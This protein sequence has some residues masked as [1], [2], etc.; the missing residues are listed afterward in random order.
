MGWVRKVCARLCVLVKLVSLAGVLIPC[1]LT[2]A[3]KSIGPMKRKTVLITGAT[4]GIGLETAKIF[5]T[6]GHSVLLHGRN[7]AKLEKVAQELSSFSLDAVIEQYVADFSQIEDVE[8]LAKAV[9]KKH[10]KLDILINNAGVLKSAKTVVK[11]GLDVRFMVNT[12]APYLLTKRLLPLFNESGR[13]INLSSAAQSPVNLKALSG[14]VKLRDMEA[15]AQSK[16]ALTMWS[17]QLAL[18]HPNGPVIV[19][20]NPGSLLASKMVKE[21]FGVSGNKLSIGADILV[22]ASLSDEFA[23]ASGQ[24]YDNDKR[25]FA[26]PHADALNDQKSQAVMAAINGILKESN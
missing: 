8:A 1:A 21:A 4:D 10:K 20:V 2:S 25:A 24:Y 26:R 19:A 7:P 17:R 9:S 12:V 14:G 23:G 11:S 22:R 13:I 16:L 6:Q 3:P 18:S 5:V 15:Y